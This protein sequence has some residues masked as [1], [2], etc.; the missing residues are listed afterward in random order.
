MNITKGLPFRFLMTAAIT[1]IIL[2]G[3]SQDEPTID[4]TGYWSGKILNPSAKTAWEFHMYLEQ[5]GRE[6][7]GVYSDYRGGITIRNTSYD[8]EN[9]GFIIDVYPE[10]VT[11]FGMVDSSSYMSGTWSY[12]GDDN[13][14]TWYLENDA[15]KIDTG[16]EDDE[17]AGDSSNPFSR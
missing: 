11:F 14:G 13:N 10:I 6:I 15:S 2:T 9:I 1:F 7:S 16:D 12:S 4:V 8:G 5:D 17:P 3:C